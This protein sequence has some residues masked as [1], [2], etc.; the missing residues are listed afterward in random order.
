M[1]YQFLR[2]SFTAAILLSLFAFFWFVFLDGTPQSRLDYGVRVEDQQRDFTI[3]EFEIP[4]IGPYAAAGR[5]FPKG[6]W[7]PVNGES[8]TVDT[9]TV[10]RVTGDMEVSKGDCV[11]VAVTTYFSKSENSENLFYNHVQANTFHTEFKKRWV[12][13]TTGIL[14]FNLHCPKTPGKYWLFL[15]HHELVDLKTIPLAKMRITVE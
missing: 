4:K 6:N 2:F 13:D 5:G 7:Q 10:L 14:D 9:K 15:C 12:A 11:P 1:N 8:L 3:V